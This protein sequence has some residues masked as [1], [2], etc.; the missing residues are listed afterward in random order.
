MDLYLDRAAAAAG[1]R[2]SETVEAGVR[3]AGDYRCVECG[4]G[5]VTF[6]L[7]PT[8]PMCHGAAWEVARWSP[9]T[10]SARARQRALPED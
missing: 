2:E 8:C 3:G 9:F 1:V 6:G 5:I 7:V 10:A 4:Y